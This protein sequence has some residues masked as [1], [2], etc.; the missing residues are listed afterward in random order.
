VL[1]LE[2]ETVVEQL[3]SLGTETPAAVQIWW[4]KVM[5]LE[6]SAGSQAS[7]RQQD[8]SPMKESLEQMH[9]TSRPQLP[10]PLA[11]N[12]LAQSVCFIGLVWAGVEYWRDS[13]DSWERWK[14][15]TYSA[16]GQTIELG[17]G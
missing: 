2:P 12:L 14:G 7:M 1:V 9:F 16:G 17:D 6:T 11:R 4:A 3:G 10:M 13:V 8:M 15:R 5:A